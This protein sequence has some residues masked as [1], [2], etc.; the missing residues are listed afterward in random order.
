MSNTEKGTFI[1]DM[2][3]L[4][5]YMWKDEKKHY[6]ECVDSDK[7]H[8]FLTLKRIRDH[9]GLEGYYLDNGESVD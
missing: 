9:L 7:A 5:G 6:A 3:T 8:I 2:H 4:F 1:E